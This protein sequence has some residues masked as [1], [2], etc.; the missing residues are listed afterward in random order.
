M[1]IPNNSTIIPEIIV[2]TNY[3]PEKPSNIIMRSKTLKRVKSLQKQFTKNLSKK[4]NKRNT[5]KSKQKSKTETKTV[6]AKKPIEE[7]QSNIE[8]GLGVEHEFVL[9]LD[10]MHKITNAIKLLETLNNEKL[11]TQQKSELRKIY[12]N[13]NVF[14]I[15]PYVGQLGFD[16][17]NVEQTAVTEIA[18][19][20]I[21]NLKFHNV[22]LNQLLT[23]LNDQMDKVTGKVSG[24]L[25]QKINKDVKV[26]P[27]P[28]GAHNLLF[29]KCENQNQRYGN[30]HAGNFECLS[31]KY[32]KYQ[33]DY[34]G[35]YHFWITLPHF[36]NDSIEDV[37]RIH[38]NAINLLQTLEPL[39]C[40]L[41]GSCDPN[42]GLNN[43]QK[44][45]KGSFRTANN[46]FASFGTT[47]PSMYQNTNDYISTNPIFQRVIKKEY[48][49]SKKM[50]FKM[51][52]NDVVN[53]VSNKIDVR[54]TPD[55]LNYSDANKTSYI[56]TDFRRKRGIKGFEFR[57]W[58]HFP[59]KY[60]K[61]LLKA[62]YLICVYGMGLNKH[63]F[64]F[65]IENQDWNNAMRDALMEGYQMK[66]NNKYISFIQKQF[67]IKL[68]GKFTAESLMNNILEN[69]WNV[70]MKTDNLKDTYM[71]MV[72]DDKNKIKIDNINKMSQ[73]FAKKT[74]KH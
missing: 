1:D 8:W 62:V 58:D 22:T 53:T 33:P 6:S 17:I 45:L 44:L 71:L 55:Y 68:N 38:Q 7:P 21:K 47:P 60:L 23:E 46:Y 69:I 31:N 72:D 56:G 49:K 24:I 18:M 10:G 42:I 67:K 14:Y 34:T 27:T 50:D 19:F 36:N 35:S 40:S 59:Q 66:I 4:K 13:N 2:D 65:S 29:Q 54:Q 12:Q 57:I 74:M 26:T 52:Y 32:L 20:E 5:K 11:N 9:T 3:P 70:V 25:T 15:I 51:Y 41:Y 64:D 63:K 61:N 39:F 48:I 43:V 28:F 16:F 37:Y 30:T 73:D